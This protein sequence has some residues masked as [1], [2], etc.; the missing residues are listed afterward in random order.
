MATTPGRPHDPT[1]H[2]RTRPEAEEYA[3]KN[4]TTSDWF[5][6]DGQNVEMQRPSPIKVG[7]RRGAANAEKAKGEADKWFA[8]VASN[9]PDP[10][11]AARCPTAESQKCHDKIYGKEESWFKH[12]ENRDYFSARDKPPRVTS[13]AGKEVQKKHGRS[14]TM[15]W[16]RHEHGAGDVYTDPP[17]KHRDG[18]MP[19]AVQQQKNKKT[20]EWFTHSSPT[21]DEPD[22]P[23]PHG[24]TR[25]TSADAEEY[26]ER[27]RYGSAS[28]WFGHDTQTDAQVCHSPRVASSEGAE[29]AK[30]LQGESESWFNHEANRNLAPPKASKS[31]SS[32]VAQ[33]MVAKSRG[34]G[35]SAVLNQ[36]QND[37]CQAARPAGRAIKPEA[38]EVAAKN[39]KG[40]MEKYLDQSQNKDYSSARPAPRVKA[41]AQATFEKNKGVMSDCMGGYPG[42]AAQHSQ[43]R[44]RPEAS[45]IAE[46]NK[47]S[48]ATV[49]T[50]PQSLPQSSRHPRVKAEAAEYAERNKGTLGSLMGGYSEMEI[51]SK[52][53]PRLKTQQAEEIAERNKGSLGPV[54]RMEA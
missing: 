25:V 6:H 40:L 3:V 49:M 31:S 36:E 8:H 24:N 9:P 32:P 18:P 33:E 1:V 48:V 11:P 42:P 53:A 29:I 43:K 10:K 5:R 13:E 26:L 54:L 22:A 21:K 19:G 17:A 20:G 51:S 50:N 12:D 52:P 34:Q 30:R 15:G 16:Y 41:E 47:G 39:K 23:A 7:D 2:P 35:M 14:D 28:H 38:E 4:R 46:K 27:D 45:E 44:V 37:S